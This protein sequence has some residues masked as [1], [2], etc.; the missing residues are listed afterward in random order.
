MN[1][2]NQFNITNEPERRVRWRNFYNLDRTLTGNQ[3]LELLTTET[4]GAVFE[5]K[6]TWNLKF[7]VTMS[8]LMVKF[9]RNAN[10]VNTWQ[11]LY[12]K[13]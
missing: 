5:N 6:I 7:S 10:P 11:R 1:K 4:P 9:T 3:T 12:I 2:W 8:T 13:R